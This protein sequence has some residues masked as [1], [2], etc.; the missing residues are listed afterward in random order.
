MPEGGLKL[1]GVVEKYHGDLADD[2]RSGRILLLPRNLYIWATMN[3][4]DQSL[5]PID[6]AFKRRW[7]W[8][9]VKI[10]DAGK[11]W[12]IKCGD[13][14]CDWWKFVQEIN[15]VIATETSSDDKKLGYFFCKPD[16]GRITISEEKMVGKVLFYLWNDVFKDGDTS[17]FKVTESAGEP[18]F[19][20]FYTTDAKGATVVDASAL[21]QFLVNVVGEEEMIDDFEV[22][23]DNHTTKK[24]R[25]RLDGGEAKEMLEIARDLVQNYADKHPEY[26]A[27][28]IIS[29]IN[30]KCPKKELLDKMKGNF[31][32]ENKQNHCKRYEGKKDNDEPVKLGNEIEEIYVNRNWRQDTNFKKFIEVA[33]ENNWGEITPDE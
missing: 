25:F 24:P 12:M 22:E 26:N 2:I 15:K 14:A 27:E 16:K 11:G 17:I 5:F 20:D 7:D 13:E 21:R 31:L 6:S 18:S 32:V 9:Y 4:S 10:S 33:K 3:T 23:G 30:G 1:D 19:E 8:H 29:E 28:Q